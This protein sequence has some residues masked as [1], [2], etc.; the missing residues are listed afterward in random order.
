METTPIT[1]VQAQGMEKGE[2]ELH[3]RL[4]RRAGSPT[5]MGYSEIERYRPDP[6]RKKGWAN[7]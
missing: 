2:L 6:N 7:N 1:K 4:C 5:R 3:T